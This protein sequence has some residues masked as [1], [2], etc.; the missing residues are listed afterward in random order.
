M[1]GML[2]RAREILARV[3]G[4]V[5][6]I[7]FTPNAALADDVEICAK[8]QEPWARLAAC[9]SV[10]DGGEWQG[11]RAGWAH[12]NRAMAHAELGN[13]NDAFDDHD[14]AIALDPTNH[15]AWN[16]RATSH[17]RFRAYDRAFADYTRALGLDPAYA[18]ALINRA[19]LF[20]EIGQQADARADYDRAI[21]AEAAAGRDTAALE[22]LR[23]DVACALGDWE[24]AVSDRQAALSSGVVDVDQMR[25]T[26][27]NTGYLPAGSEAGDD[28]EAALA[29]W[30][31]AGCPWDE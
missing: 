6:L 21:A 14:K 30:S 1:N 18:T 19:S 29:A 28:I 10:L 24:A 12:S 31:E 13:H 23:A 17:A 4:V 25:E 22:F 16:N 20:A 11:A 7:A 15:R 5:A 26:L 9:T 27:A 3:L 2:P 8:A